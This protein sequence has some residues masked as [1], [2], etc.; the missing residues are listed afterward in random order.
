MYVQ[1]KM[2]D[3]Q[4][5]KASVVRKMDEQISNLPE[6]NFDYENGSLDFSCTKLELT[7]YRDEKAE[8]SFRVY[9][10]TG[11]PTR[12]RV[13]SSESRMRCITEEFLGEEEEIFYVF[14]QLYS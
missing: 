7:L 3:I 9:G 8:G 10:P 14:A 12:G 6:G 2:R 4:I 11:R 1:R 5:Q 13:Y